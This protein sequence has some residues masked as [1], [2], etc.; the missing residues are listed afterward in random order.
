M[1][2]TAYIAALLLAGAVW[3]GSAAEAPL[4]ESAGAETLSV[5][6]EEL[7]G[8][9]SVGVIGETPAGFLTAMDLGDGIS[10]HPMD[11]SEFAPDGKGPM[12]MG[13]LRIERDGVMQTADVVNLEGASP[14]LDE[15]LRG[16]FGADGRTV[17]PEGVQKIAVFNHLLGNAGAMLNQALL[18][19]IAR[20][21]RETGEP[22]PYSIVHTELRSVEALHL[23]Q[24]TGDALVY[25]T[26]GRVLL[27]LDGWVFPQYMKAYLWKDGDSY[28]LI[29][30]GSNDSQKDAAQEAGDRLVRRCTAAG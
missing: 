6:S 4:P 12:M 3:T 10:Y 13:Q 20:V 11:F 21:R 16:L 28:R 19:G 7:D 2:K 1:K 22:M 23:M 18:E 24:D 26:G 5:L 30:V 8:A 29:A 27:Y 25:T 14:E 17:T 15:A 9:A